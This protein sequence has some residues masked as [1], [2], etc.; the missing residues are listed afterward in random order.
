MFVYVSPAMD[1]G[2]LMTPLRDEAS[3]DGWV[4]EFSIYIVYPAVLI[5]VFTQ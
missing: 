5:A 3:E 2:P 4:K 1:S